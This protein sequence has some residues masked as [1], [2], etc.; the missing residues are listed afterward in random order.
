MC[1]SK[2]PPEI[3]R[4]SADSEPAAQTGEQQNPSFRAKALSPSK[5]K[6]RKT[7]SM[8]WLPEPCERSAQAWRSTARA[9]AASPRRRNHSTE[10]VAHARLTYFRRILKPA[11]S[12]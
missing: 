8:R 10:P 6:R 9:C 7:T 3:R 11:C 4:S 12:K 1:A 5:G 2:K